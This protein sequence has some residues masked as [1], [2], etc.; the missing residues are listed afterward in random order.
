[1]FAGKSTELMRII[2]T[3]RAIDKIVLPIN[4]ILNNRFG[5]SSI[6]THDYTEGKE[7]SSESCLIASALDDISEFAIREADVI[8]IEELQ[9]FPDAFDQ[10][11]KWVDEWGKTVVAAGLVGDSNR[12]PFGDVLRLI[13]Y[14]DEVQKLNAMCSHCRD[15]T[16][17]HF[18][19][20][21]TNQES[22]TLVGS[23]EYDAVCRRH[24][25]QTMTTENEENV[26]LHL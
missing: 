6:T 3:Y 23:S 12:N 2:R 7:D 1:M 18:S 24:Y 21:N 5:T 10:V 20:C 11:V 25:L 9:F 4:H 13:P 16:L 8:V 19:I 17:A 22:Q 26:S 15:G 14:A